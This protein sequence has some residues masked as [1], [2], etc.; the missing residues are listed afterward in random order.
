MIME[1][2]HKKIFAEDEEII[3]YREE[4]YKEGGPYSGETASSARY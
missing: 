3:I 1:L 4:E 2:E